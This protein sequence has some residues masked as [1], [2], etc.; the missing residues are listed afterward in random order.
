MSAV[1]RLYA[2]VDADRELPDQSGA[3]GAGLAMVRA[4]GLAVVVS[5]EDSADTGTD[6][7]ALDHLDV[8]TSLVRDGPVIPLRFG[9]IAPDEAAV[10]DEVLT[11]S[12][13]VFQQRLD[14][15][16]SVVEVVATVEFDEDAAVRAVMSGQAPTSGD[17]SLSDRV[18]LGEEV[19]ERLAAATEEWA[20]ELLGAV[21]EHAEAVMPLAPPEPASVRYAMLVRRDRLSDM[22]TEMQHVPLAGVVPC[23]IEYVGPLPPV[24]FPARSAADDAP[25][26]W[27]W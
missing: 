22:D 2:V 1:L 26:R 17:G 16:A 20:D 14:A 19:V 13:D 15:T 5:H 11:P 18:A 21:V 4:E 3:H 27:G 23:H 8:I 10:R 9:T 12:Q 25:S 7:D 6:Q 24:D